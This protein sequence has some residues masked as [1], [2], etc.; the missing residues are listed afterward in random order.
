[1][2]D[3]KSVVTQV[4]EFFHFF[5]AESKIGAM[6][7]RVNRTLEV[8]HEVEKLASTYAEEAQA[9]I[10][11]CKANE[12]S[13][14]ADDYEKTDVP[15]LRNKLGSVIKFGREGRPEIV[16]LKT[17]ALKTW[18]AWVTKCKSTSRTLPVAPEGLEPETLSNTLSAL[19][20]TQEDRR[21]ALTQELKELEQSKV[22][23]FDNACKELSSRLEEI[24]NKSNNLQ[25]T[26]TEQKATVAD[27]LDQANKCNDDLKP[28]QVPFDELCELK[29]NNRAK[30]TMYSEHNEVDQLI[31]HLKRLTDQNTAALITEDNNNRIDAY[32]QKANGV[33][34]VAKQLKKD[35]TEIQGEIYARLEAYLAKQ[36]EI[37]EKREIVKPLQPDFEAL[38]KDGLHL[39][40]PKTPAYLDQKFGNVLTLAIQYVQGCFTEMVKSYDALCDGIL[41]NI[42]DL[43]KQ[44]G[45]LEG[46]LEAQKAKIE[47][48]T[49]SAKAIDVSPIDPPYAQILK[50]NLQARVKHLPDDVKGRLDQLMSILA[51]IAEDNKAA[52]IED[53][54]RKRIEAYN[55][56]AEEQATI[57]EDYAKEI[58]AISGELA[59]RRTTFLNNIPILDTKR[60]ASQEALQAPYA[61]LEKDGIHQSV[62]HTPNSVA[63]TYASILSEITNKLNEIYKEMVVNFDNLC[64]PIIENIR[65]REND[66]NNLPDALADRKTHLADL[67]EKCKAIQEGLSVLDAPFQELTDFKLNYQAKST[68][69]DIHGFADQ[70]EG[71]LKHLIQSN[72]AAMYAEE[73]A[74]RIKEYTDKATIVMSD[75]K[76]IETEIEGIQGE[77]LE[78][79]DK[80]FGCQKKAE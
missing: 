30:N 40:I 12:N 39:G 2:P 33:H 79:R 3:E 38:E 50:Y 63:G 41:A 9:V 73:C 35:L 16:T 75:G 37:Q 13:I 58:S 55:V 19:D 71:R 8:Q 56:K 80:Y 4:S 17:K 14:M 72:D 43:T 15:S 34:D 42:E 68:P 1:M 28:M 46:D 22:D 66:A 29:L 20:K 21:N 74:N 69:N 24:R 52:I 64:N 10:D 47:Q 11:S 62:K 61:D 6:V 32:N 5:A 57:A 36:A 76:A 77:L 65:G 18:N 60:D 44:S 25:G 59:E 78:K 51:K 48:L 23:S 31:A 70:L 7:D 53:N 49:E 45:E 27:L 54:N 26:L 67:L